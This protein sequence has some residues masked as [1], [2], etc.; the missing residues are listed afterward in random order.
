VFEL[1]KP[2]QHF[3]LLQDL[4]GTWHHALAVFQNESLAQMSRVAGE[5][6][7][8]LTGE[9]RQAISRIISMVQPVTEGFVRSHAEW[10]ADPGDPW[11][12]PAEELARRALL[13]PALLVALAH[14]DAHP[15]PFGADSP[16]TSSSVVIRVMI[17]S[18][19]NY[20]RAN[21]LVRD[22][23]EAED[24]GNGLHADRTGAPELPEGA[25]T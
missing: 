12:G 11:T 19:E 7:E 24:V 23:L 18:R 2:A 3:E 15:E 13:F 21:D 6:P 17:E 9:E 4:F 14:I 16:I 10:D 1:R 20:R 8:A 5:D 25:R 22:T